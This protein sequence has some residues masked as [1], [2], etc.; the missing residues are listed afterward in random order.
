MVEDILQRFYSDDGKGDGY[1]VGGSRMEELYAEWGIPKPKAM[2]LLTAIQPVQSA[3]MPSRK[4]INERVRLFLAAAAA[5]DALPPWRNRERTSDAAYTSMMN[6]GLYLA[7]PFLSSL[8]GA[9]DEGPMY[10]SFRDRDRL[11]AKRSAVLVVLALEAYRREHRAYPGNLAELVPTHL[12]RVPL[13]PFDGSAMRYRAP[14]GGESRPLL[15]SVGA[16]GVDDGGLMPTTKEDRSAVS[17]LPSSGSTGSEDGAP[18]PKGDWVLWP[19]P[20]EPNGG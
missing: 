16:D 10:T 19:V 2:G 6:S 18:L 4:E 14:S 5:D 20:L 11:E 3:V 12:P 15:Y 13:D 7:V 17:R 8:Q 9:Q 1:Y